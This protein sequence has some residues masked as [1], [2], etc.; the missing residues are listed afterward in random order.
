MS[1]NPLRI[2]RTL[3][4]TALLVSTATIS[5]ACVP[6]SPGEASLPDGVGVSADEVRDAVEASPA[7]A[8]SS[9][10]LTPPSGDS[11]VVANSS[12][13]SVQIPRDADGA[14]SL[15]STAGG[16]TLGL[17]LPEGTAAGS[18][19]IVGP[20]L[21]AY[22]SAD[23]AATAVQ[24]PEAGGVAM[25]RVLSSTDLPNNQVFPV[26]LPPGASIEVA[27]EGHGFVV[28]S[29]GDVIFTI[30][31]PWA[32]DGDGNH[33]PTH[34]FSPDGQSLVQHV[35][36]DATTPTPITLDPWWRTAGNYA[37]CVLGIGVPAGFAVFAIG[38]LGVKSALLAAMNSGKG[39]P[40][41]FAGVAGRQY[42]RWVWDGCSRF[43][44]S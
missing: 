32:V 3:A 2:R 21:V 26:D 23:D 13:A 39:L 8:A 14:V 37:R 16:H 22:P 17:D 9:E 36:F 1:Y 15:Q 10:Y 44:R 35:D 43:L 42:A 30:A 24:L 7:L 31:P 29:A 20:G 6:P 25:I 4:A 5:A 18:A 38:A 27:V 12:E 28:D 34:Y 41:G 40:P 33:L 19:E 11:I